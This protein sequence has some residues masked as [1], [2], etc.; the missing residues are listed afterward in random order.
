MHA[1]QNRR[2][3]SVRPSDLCAKYS[4]KAGQEDRGETDLA[5]CRHVESHHLYQR[6]GQDVEVADDAKDALP[7]RQPQIIVPTASVGCRGKPVIAGPRS[8]EDQIGDEAG[9]VE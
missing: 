5:W 1:L 8:T 3:S 2:Q 7:G 9:S 4:Q 6:N